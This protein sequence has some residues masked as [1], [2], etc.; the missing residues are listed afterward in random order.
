MTRQELADAIKWAVQNNVQVLR[1]AES[2]R[3]CHAAQST[4]HLSSDEVFARSM[5]DDR[6]QY[7]SALEVAAQLADQN[8]QLADVRC[9]DQIT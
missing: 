8:P 5:W 9:E 3:M 7:V 6:V 4:P 2:N 1:Y